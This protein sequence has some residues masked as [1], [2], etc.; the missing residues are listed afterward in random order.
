MN[1][2][3]VVFGLGRFGKS[4]AIELA[5]AGADVL[6]IDS[7]KER[8]HEVADIVTC[9]IKAD[10]CDSET[11]LS[12]GISNMDAAII[13]ITESLDASIM[14]TI[15]AKDAGVPYVFAKAK[16]ATHMKI[17]NKVGADKV[18]IP[19]HE[20]G[21]R[22]ARQILT[23]NILDFVEL[24]ERIRMVEIAMRPEWTGK[25]LRQLNL[26]QTEQINVVAIRQNE[27]VRVIL[28]PDEPL[29]PGTTL[30]IIV[31]KKDLARL[32]E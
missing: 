7:D 5:N 24:S 27:E 11:L 1:K 4:I 15:F 13:A 32:T 16:D 28:D 17:L 2:S 21:I 23:G 6:A 31:D 14:A 12:L 22:V 29:T 9:A 18:I 8:V 19:E 3:I 25:S 20:S 30:L 10:A 26:R